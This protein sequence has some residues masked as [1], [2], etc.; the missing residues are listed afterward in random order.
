MTGNATAGNRSRSTSPTTTK[1]SP[2]ATRNQQL[3]DLVG[4][5]PNAGR[6]TAH[7]YIWGTF[8]TMAVGAISATLSDGF[9]DPLAQV[10][11]SAGLVAAA[12][13]VRRARRTAHYSAMVYPLIPS[14]IA[15]VLL[16]SF[17]TAGIAGALWLQQNG[18]INDFLGIGIDCLIAIMTLGIVTR[19]ATR[20]RVP[21]GDYLPDGTPDD[22]ADEIDGVIEP[23]KRT[24]N[25]K[26]TTPLLG[27]PENRIAADREAVQLLQ[28]LVNARPSIYEPHFAYSLHELG[29]T[30]CDVG[31]AREAITPL[32]QAIQIRRRL[33]TANPAAY[34][35]DL[36]ISLSE[37]SWALSQTGRQANALQHLREA[38]EIWKW[39]A[40]ANPVY[41][42]QLATALRTLGASLFETGLQAD[43]LQC[44]RLETT[45]RRRLAT[46]NPAA[47]EP[48][49][50][51]SL[52][53]LG[54]LL[55]EMQSWHNALE[56]LRQ[57]T[58]IR[59]RLAITNPA[60]YNPDL[61]TSLHEL[62][63]ALSQA[64]READAL[65][66]LRQAAKIRQQ[67][68][69]SNPGAFE[70][71][72]AT[73]LDALGIVLSYAGRQADALE[74]SRQAAEI[75]QRLAE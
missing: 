1:I 19:Y 75:R 51:Y 26:T 71:V 3:R 8:S 45:I 11:A 52:H 42:S 65:E 70:P 13:I 73:T 21:T 59:Q 7:L 9:P 44:L 64:G 67:L 50:A 18:H 16:G 10:L 62:G 69:K 2:T 15:G 54:W 63:C 23:A 68:A 22:V 5:L 33:A 66:P 39:L 53:E 31:R 29:W 43:M 25:P 34:N 37:L 55:V 28:V 4:Q 74:T 57:A 47:N 60:A 32:G 17:Y 49:L 41:E 12:G 27:T 40:K 20:I 58:Q 36:A 35:P 56:P 24:S 46:A 72:L 61:A 48:D 38:A 14:I 6:F 30:L